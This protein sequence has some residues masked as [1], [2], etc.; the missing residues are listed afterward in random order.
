MAAGI[1]KRLLARKLNCREDE[2]SEKGYYVES[3]GTGACSGA[4]ATPEAVE[5]LRGRG[6]DI[7]GHRSQPLGFEQINRADF[8][9]AMTGRHL[10]TVRALL[11]RADQ[12]LSKVNT[13]DIEDPIGGSRE[14]YVQCADRIEQALRRRLEEVEL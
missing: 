12:R 11:P 3:A 14:E 6:I 4:P 5:A 10:E 2:L 9:Y 8:I 13:E 1:L 7:S